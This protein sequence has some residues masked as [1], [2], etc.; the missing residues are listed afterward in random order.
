M[1][2][3]SKPNWFVYDTC[4][5]LCM[6]LTELLLLYATLVLNISFIKKLFVTGKTFQ[7]IINFIIC[8]CLYL[9]CVF[10]HISCGRTDPGV[11]PNSNDKGEILLPIELQSQTISIRSC[12]KCNNLKPPRTHHCSVCK[13]CI[14]K[15]DHHCPWI[16]NCVG[17]NNQKHFLLFLAYV[18]FF[19]LYS[20]IVVCFQFYKCMS[21]PE[22]YPNDFDRT[23]LDDQYLNPGSELLNYTRGSNDMFRYECAITPVAFILGFSVVIESLIFGIFC[24]AM[25]IDQIVCIV[26]NTTGI[27]HL[28]Q[29]YLYSKKKNAYSLFIQVFGSK[30]SWK[31]FLPTMTRSPF[32]I[33]NFD[34]SEFLDI[35]FGD[36]IVDP[37]SGFDCD[38][39]RLGKIQKGEG[40]VLHNRMKSNRISCSF[41]CQGIDS[42]NMS[43]PNVSE[44]FSIFEGDILKVSD[45][46]N[47]QIK[48]ILMDDLHK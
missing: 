14:F 2:I 46:K 16:N 9:I 22:P 36:L 30:F 13:R 37:E 8:N 33:S 10:C 40:S 35:E 41:F 19:C 17:I 24:I 47:D 34:I 43:I 18:F 5:I 4:G 39:L 3:F 38:Q 44:D 45:M 6:I 11:I 48:E 15:M 20:L 26:N 31:W 42:T 28:K 27:E 32:T 12:S 23:F 25:F 21:Y 29:E 1:K 7:F